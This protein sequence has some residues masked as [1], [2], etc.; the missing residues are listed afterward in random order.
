MA[1]NYKKKEKYRRQIK[2]KKRENIAAVRPG[3]F[4]KSPPGL[5]YYRIWGHLIFN[6]RKPSTDIDISG[7]LISSIKYNNL[8]EGNAIKIKIIAGVIVQ[9]NSINVPWF[10]YLC[11][12]PAVKFIIQI[13]K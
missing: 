13:N 2:Q 8:N 9:I 7:S 11:D 1:S 10:K 5:F 4:S 6:W 3:D 12:I